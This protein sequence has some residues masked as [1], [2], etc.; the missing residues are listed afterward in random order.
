M[1]AVVTRA[2][3]TTELRELDVPEPGEGEILLALR[4]CGLCG[5]DLFKLAH[6]TAPPG[7]VL[8]HELVGE[9]VAAGARAPFELG[10]R[11]VVPHH[12]A[13]GECALC[14]RGAET[15]C[16]TFRENQLAP[17]GFAER[18]LVRRLAAER[19]ARRVPDALPDDAAIF[20]EPAACVLRGI[21]R[22]ALPPRDAGAAAV[23]GA[24]SMGLLHLLIL[25][26]LRPEIAVAIVDPDEARR[27]RALELGADLA[28]APVNAASR[29]RRELAL[30]PLL[31]GGVDAVFDTVGGDATL[32]LGLELLREGG[33]LVL[34]AHAGAG[35]RGGLDLN[36]LFKAERR[37]VGT[38]SGALGEQDRV[39]ALLTG[40]HLDPTP[41]VTHHLPL[42]RFDEA[43][44]LCRERRALKV[45]L[46]PAEESAAMS[47]GGTPGSPVPRDR[48]RRRP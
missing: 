23:L 19:A 9:V 14:R 43:V 36:A 40:G 27:E 34:F 12:V 32:R 29:I 25:R 3:G 39:F 48:A 18:I 20:L 17:G 30:D 13:C 21:D 5:T 7:T 4:A 42:S 6:D 47:R 8:G 28:A 38:Y 35:E 46:Q 24:G 26:A 44:A 41:L 10:A 1:K 16:S 31:R 22:A 15:A 33:T 37:I 11:V 2:G 45:V